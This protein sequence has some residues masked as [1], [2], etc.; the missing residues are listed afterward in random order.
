MFKAT[1]RKKGSTGQLE[2]YDQ[3]ALLSLVIW[4]IIQLQYILAKQEYLN[5]FP[6]F[7]LFCITI[8][9]YKFLFRNRR[10]V[11][12]GK[13]TPDFEEQRYR[14]SYRNNYKASVL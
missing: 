3:L 12:T 4:N 11:K 8:I 2:V 6:L 10:V 7:H 13:L 14:I 5:F 9:I 1:S